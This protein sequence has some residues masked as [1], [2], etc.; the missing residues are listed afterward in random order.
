MSRKRV[1]SDPQCKAL[2]EWYLSRGSLSEKAKELGVSMGTLRDAILRG[3][4]EPTGHI[5]RKIEKL[6]PRETD[7]ESQITEVA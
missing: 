2:A 4:N 1:L 6:V 7:S 5:R 3:M